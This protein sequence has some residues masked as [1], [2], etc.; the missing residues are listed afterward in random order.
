MLIE[1]FVSEI[2]NLNVTNLCFIG[3]SNCECGTSPSYLGFRDT[4]ARSLPCA[5]LPRRHSRERLYRVLLLPRATVPRILIKT[6]YMN[7]KEN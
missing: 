4:T 3:S 1:L 6:S 5:T 2:I 7:F